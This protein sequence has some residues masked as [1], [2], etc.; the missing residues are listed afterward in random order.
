MTNDFLLDY[1]TKLLIVQYNQ[2]PKAKATMQAILKTL[3]L[4]EVLE[5]MET[6]FNI[7]TAKGHQLDVIAR[8]YNLN[9]NIRGVTFIDD[10]FGYKKYSTTSSIFKGY[11]KYGESIPVAKFAKYGDN[12][13]V[14][15]SLPDEQLRKFIYLAI[16]KTKNKATLP[17]LANSLRGIYGDDFQII[18]NAL[19]LDYKFKAKDKVLTQLADFS[20]LIPKPAGIKVVLSYDL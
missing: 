13:N 17:D 1:Y 5:G 20:G 6:A 11:R 7:D 8:Y 12:Q 3:A 9:R 2:K 16:E 15:Y 10:F 19:Q 14:F 4:I 18:E